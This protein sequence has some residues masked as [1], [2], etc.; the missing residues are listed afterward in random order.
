MDGVFLTTSLQLSQGDGTTIDEALLVV[1]VG[2]GAEVDPTAP[3]LSSLA[4][5]TVELNP[6]W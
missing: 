1:M 2:L 6:G 3:L 4:Q 5:L